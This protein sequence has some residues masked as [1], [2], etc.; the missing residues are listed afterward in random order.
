MK[1]FLS[2][3]IAIA[4][5]LSLVTVPALAVT[6]GARIG[7]VREAAVSAKAAA[8]LGEALNV[9]GG[10]LTFE[11][12]T[13][14]P[15]VV[16]GDVAMSSNAGVSSS[17]S[18]VWTTVNAE[19]GAVLSFD[20]ISMGEGSDTRD[21]DGLRVYVDS[22]KILQKGSNHLDFETFNYELTEGEHV[23]KFTYK[24]DGSVNGTGDYA[25]IDNVIVAIPAPPESIEVEPVTVPATRRAGV[26]YTVLPETTV[27]K[28]VTFAI[29][30]T[31][32]ATV[33]EDGIVY[34]VAEGTTTITVASIVDQSVYGT[35]TVTVTEA[36][37]H[38]GYTFVEWDT[39]F[40][41]I[42]ENTTVT[43]VYKLSWD[44][45]EDGDVDTADALIVMRHVMNVEECEMTNMDA[46]GDGEVTVADA[47]LIMRFAMGLI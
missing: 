6:D 40:S 22:T 4:M 20:W 46:D 1:K 5:V 42:T 33:D 8:N 13:D 36:P 11:T 28:S 35:A 32:I 3:V 39:D 45:D 23:I 18:S 12:D 9:T 31:S 19:P 44:M 25:K 14:Y 34:G 16:S 2:F 15:W 41:A 7:E 43:A 21:W 47:L 30:D 17:T 37:E 38:F 24:K 10:T 26:V 27:N 29:E